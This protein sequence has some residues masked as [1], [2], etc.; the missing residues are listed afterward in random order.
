M[1]GLGRNLPHK[2]QARYD[3]AEKHP[4]QSIADPLLCP[5]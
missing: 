5:L 1:P 3:N 2:S 4:A